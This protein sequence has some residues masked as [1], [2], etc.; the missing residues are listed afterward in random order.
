ML[1]T[2]H[3][4]VGGQQECTIT[5]TRALQ[6]NQHSSAEDC[7][8]PCIDE[9]SPWTNLRPRMSELD[10]H[11]L[12]PS[13][14]KRSVVSR[15]QWASSIVNVVMT[16]KYH[17]QT[18]A[19][20]ATARLSQ[21]STISSSCTIRTKNYLKRWN[22][23]QSCWNNLLIVKDSCLRRWREHLITSKM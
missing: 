7:L 20:W 2:N 23:L 6:R 3:Q 10:L 16:G 14:M 15:K 22:H 21:A 17:L 1:S 4:R 13:S 19:A 9:E 11:W 8:L 5:K 18:M 12:T